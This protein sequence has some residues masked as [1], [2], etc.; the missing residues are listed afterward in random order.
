MHFNYPALQFWFNIIQFI[1]TGLLA[2]YV[3]RVSKQKAAESRFKKMEANVSGLPTKTDLETLKGEICGN[4]EKH[5]DRTDDIEKR[6]ALVEMRT[7]ELKVELDHL[8]TQNQFNELNKSISSLS[9]ELQNTQGRL[10]GINR[11]VDLINEFL[12]NQGGGTKA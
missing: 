1:L 8:P 9:S 10:E 3:H 4:C 5:Q 6:T 7:L 12:I 2:L 11:A